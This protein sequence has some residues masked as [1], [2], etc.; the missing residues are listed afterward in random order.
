[1]NK[2]S[3]LLIASFCFIIT[4]KASVNSEADQSEW[5]SL[6]QG[7][8]AMF[9]ASLTQQ[10]SDICESYGIPYQLTEDRLIL[11]PKNSRS[12]ILSLISNHYKK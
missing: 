1:M 7:K 6:Y 3:L 12:N 8:E 11:V 10:I 2:K 4:A 5:T 9:Q